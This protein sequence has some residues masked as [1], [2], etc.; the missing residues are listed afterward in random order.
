MERP[1]RNVV[2]DV[3]PCVVAAEVAGDRGTALPCRG[4][5]PEVPGPGRQQ[6]PDVPEAADQE[7][8][9]GAEHGRQCELDEGNRPLHGVLVDERHPEPVTGM[10]TLGIGAAA[11]GATPSHAAADGG[12]RGHDRGT[13]EAGT[14]A[15][16]QGAV[17]EADLRVEA[18]HG[19]EQV[20]TDEDR[21]LGAGEDLPLLVVLAL[22]QLARLEAGHAAAVAIDP[23]PHVLEVPGVGAVE[24][25]GAHD[26]RIHL[27]GALDEAT[28][29]RPVEHQVVVHEEVEG[30]TA[31]PPPDHVGGRTESGRVRR[32]HD[33]GPGQDAGDALGEPRPVARVDDQHLEVMVVLDTDGSEDL[34]EPVARVVGHEDETDERGGG[35]RPGTGLPTRRGR[36]AGV[37]PAVARVG[38][39]GTRTLVPG[40][41]A[42]SAGGP[43]V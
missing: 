34:F 32:L 25:L 39:H 20:R 41:S 29:G 27:E 13:D 33:L 4:Q 16:V 1:V 31:L 7:P 9:E 5:A 6:A 2:S 17:E 36:I 23:A 3:E 19:L 38:V 15:E 21:R 14:P 26:T 22:V 12:R 10:Q 24:H 35:G 18:T 40:A 37:L 42:I 30:G 43:A 11:T 28:D 8:V